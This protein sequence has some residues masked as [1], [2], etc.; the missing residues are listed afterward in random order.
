M[1][2][3]FTYSRVAPTELVHFK[4]LH[5][6]LWYNLVHIDCIIDVCV[7]AEISDLKSTGV[8]CVGFTDDSI[9]AREDLYDIFV[10]GE[11]IAQC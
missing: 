2:Q 3:S 8:Y 1:H 5:Y 11:F 6:T 4:T 10:D 9:R 7:D